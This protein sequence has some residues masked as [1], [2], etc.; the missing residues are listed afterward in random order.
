MHPRMCLT[1][2]QS[3][4]DSEKTCYTKQDNKYTSR[5]INFNGHYLSLAC[6]V[7]ISKRESASEIC[8]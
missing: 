8:E 5:G 4:V 7:L 6:G 3:L 2:R 1:S